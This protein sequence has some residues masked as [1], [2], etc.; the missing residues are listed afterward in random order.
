MLE[1]KT[2]EADWWCF[3]LWTGRVNFCMFYVL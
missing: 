3:Q 2:I 1:E